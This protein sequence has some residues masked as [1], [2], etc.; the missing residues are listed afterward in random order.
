[1]ASSRSVQYSQKLT[2]SLQ[3]PLTQAR[4][5]R[6]LAV[7]PAAE[8]VSQRVE[9]NWQRLNPLLERWIPFPR[10]LHSYPQ[11]RFAARHLGSVRMRRQ[12]F[13]LSAP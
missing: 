1:M 4:Q 12:P 9:V 13:P 11:A 5:G 10:V 6:H 3:T 8:P 7:P 2:L